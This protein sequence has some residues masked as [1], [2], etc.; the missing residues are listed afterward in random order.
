MAE[1]APSLQVLLIRIDVFDDAKA[2]EDCQ[3]VWP[4]EGAAPPRSSACVEAGS[5]APRSARA[6]CGAAV[7]ATPLTEPEAVELARVMAALADP[8]RLR[9]LSLVASRREVCS[10]ELEAPLHRSQPTVSHHTK[11]L[12]E[13]GLITGERRGR[14]TWWHVNSEALRSIAQVLGGEGLDRS[15]R[16]RRSDEV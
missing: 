11:V 1:E 2:I 6:A 10:C 4:P 12:A 5:T 16:P 3:C 14:W 15:P 9:L 13:A 8:V 7:T